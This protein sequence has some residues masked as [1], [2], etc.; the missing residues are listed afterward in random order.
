MVSTSCNRNNADCFSLSTFKTIRCS[1]GRRAY[2]ED[3]FHQGIQKTTD[4]SSWLLP[5]LKTSRNFS[6]S[7]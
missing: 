4:E 6:Q 3:A 1:A 5:N 7:L 2:P